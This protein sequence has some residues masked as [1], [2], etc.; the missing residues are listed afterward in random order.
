VPP[1]VHLQVVEEDLHRGDLALE[2]CIPRSHIDLL[3]KSMKMP[4]ASDVCPERSSKITV[5]GLRWAL[6]VRYRVW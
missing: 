1:G 2:Q 3:L 5:G 4:H 6:G